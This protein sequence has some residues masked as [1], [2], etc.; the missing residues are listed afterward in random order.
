M[1]GWRK[2]SSSLLAA[3][4][5]LVPLAAT[6]A[7]KD[8]T[9]ERFAPNR[10]PALDGQSFAATINTAG[11]EATAVFNINEGMVS[12]YLYFPEQNLLR[13]LYSV[14][15][16]SVRSGDTWN[17]NVPTRGVAFTLS[18]GTDQHVVVDGRE[19]ALRFIDRGELEGVRMEKNGDCAAATMSAQSGGTAAPR[20]QAETHLK[21]KSE[22]IY[23]L[24]AL[25]Y[26]GCCD[27]CFC[28]HRQLDIPYW[29]D[30]L[31]CA[32]SC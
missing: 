12:L 20:V 32:G 4:L 9:R 3:F 7:Q 30:N 23:C 28:V 2:Y 31:C 24:M 27:S 25:Y 17:I 13:V 10:M 5:L 29:V 16:E 14:P 19:S 8:G 26:T 6:A 1:N 22:L 21:P 11:G 15:A 18:K